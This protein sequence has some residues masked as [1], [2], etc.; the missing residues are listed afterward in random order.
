MQRLLS[1]NLYIWE[2][3]ILQG[4]PFRSSPL[5]SGILTKLKAVGAAALSTLAFTCFGN[6][7]SASRTTQ[8]PVVF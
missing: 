4:L 1:Y 8:D 2:H 5:I 7:C 3:T 6:N